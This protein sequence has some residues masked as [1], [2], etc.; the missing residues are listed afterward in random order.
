MMFATYQRLGVHV[1][2]SWRDVIRA[3]STRLAANARHDPA[4][5]PSRKQFYREMLRHH[6][7]AQQIVHR[8]R[9]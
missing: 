1:F 4:R 9:L 8:F 5:R 3:A 2:A 6:R 7:D